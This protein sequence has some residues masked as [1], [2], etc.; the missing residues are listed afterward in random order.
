MN[1]TRRNKQTGETGLNGRGG[2]RE[3]REGVREGE[4]GREWEGRGKRVK[5]DSG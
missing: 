2:G 4:G 1:G 5:R 3:R